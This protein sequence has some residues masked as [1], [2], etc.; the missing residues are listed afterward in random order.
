MN[1]YYNGCLLNSNGTPRKIIKRSYNVNKREECDGFDC[2]GGLD[3]YQRILLARSHNKRARGAG[4]E[5]APEPM[6]PASSSSNTS[7]NTTSSDSTE[8]D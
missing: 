1:I 2:G 6:N 5:A 3:M 7:N 8:S 4:G